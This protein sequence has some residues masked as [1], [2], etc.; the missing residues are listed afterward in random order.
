MQ[1]LLRPKYG[2]PPNTIIPLMPRA[3]AWMQ[4]GKQDQVDV[5]ARY[6]A[7]LSAAPPA[8][9]CG[10]YSDSTV[11]LGGIINARPAIISRFRAEGSAVRVVV[12]G[13]FRINELAKEIA[14][15][16]CPG[17]PIYSTLIVIY[18]INDR[19]WVTQTGTSVVS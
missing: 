13:R 9:L 7:P 2:M 3:H 10:V 15:F 5:V 1:V 19:T 14:E 8:P 4:K 11:V 12:K 6:Y 18:Q 17:N 16:A